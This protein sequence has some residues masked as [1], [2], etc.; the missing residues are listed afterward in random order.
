[1]T[2]IDP[3]PDH[4]IPLT[5]MERKYVTAFVNGAVN[6]TAAARAAGYGA[7][8]DTKE[9]AAHAA[10]RAAYR[11]KHNPEVQAAIRKEAEALNFSSG[12]LGIQKITEIAMMDGHKDQFKA[13]IRLAEMNGFGVVQEHVVKHEHG[14]R[15]TDAQRI[16][17]ITLLAQG[18]G[19]DPRALLGNLAPTGGRLPASGD[20]RSA[21][22]ACIARA[23]VI[24]A[25]FTPVEPAT[26]APDG[27][28][29]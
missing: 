8:S 29:W 12:L 21:S 25:E 26:L 15:K 5:E 16:D 28:E 3:M 11:C 18:L 14:L 22:D 4:M 2:D 19:L 27:M 17:R 23:E 9:Q 10:Q 6:P 20:S 1:M 24:D 13:A 7:G